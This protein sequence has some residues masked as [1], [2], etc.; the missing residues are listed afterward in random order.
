MKGR[1][2]RPGASPEPFDDLAPVV[3]RLNAARPALAQTPVASL[4]AFLDDFGRRI[5]DDPAAR[6]VAGAAFLSAWLRKANL[7]RVLA[8]NLRGRPEAL[9]GF[10]PESDA[11]LGARPRGLVSMWM[12]ANVP[13]LPFFSLV[14]GLLAKNACLVKVADGGEDAASAL[15]GVLASARG[16]GLAG[17]DLAG[18]VAL[19]SFPSSARDLSEAMSLAADGKVAWG[20]AAA[21]EAI[22]ALPQAPHAV[23]VEFGPKT[24]FAVL[25]RALLADEDALSRA[26]AGLARDVHVFDQRACSSPQTVF[27]EETPAR[28]LEEVGRRLAAVLAK[29]PPKAALDPYTTL[30]IAGARAEW[31]LDPARDVIASPGGA[32]WTVLL[33]REVSLKE[34]VQS[35]T[36][37]LTGVA[38]WRDVI[39]LLTPAVQTAGIAFA[40]PGEAL[41]FAREATRAG[42]VRC[43]RPG[44]MN[45]HES[46]WDGRLLVSDLVR[47]VTVKP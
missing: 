38:S 36:V 11:L 7:E 24:S 30:A 42:V 19:V 28:P 29:L 39:P 5:L 31:A 14:P 10:V 27:V 44:L 12:A 40:D 1:L 2:L 35:R 25:D 23:N 8:L 16:G 26:L 13:T 18:A 22:R 34:P 46:P 17:A 21:L 43:V 33:D 37:F 15:L 4:V 41:A 9:D 32:Q 3:A 6:A 45:V 47:W 20:G